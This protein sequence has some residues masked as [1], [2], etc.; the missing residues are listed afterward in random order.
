MNKNKEEVIKKLKITNVVLKNLYDSLRSIYYDDDMM[1]IESP[2]QLH[3]E[4]EKEMKN[5]TNLLE[6]VK[7]M[8]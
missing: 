6:D 1:I 3:W 2:N 4:I 8:V 5:L 7:N